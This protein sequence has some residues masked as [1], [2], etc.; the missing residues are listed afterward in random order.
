MKV[1]LLQS[2]LKWHEPDVNRRHFEGMIQEMSADVD[3]VL[4]PE[5]FTTGFTMQPEAVAETIHGQSIQWMTKMA[6]EKNFAIA[7][8]LVITENDKFYNRFI[9]INPDGSLFKYDKRHLF[10]PAGE[11]EVYCSG[12]QKSIVSYKGFR[13]C[14]NICYDLRFPAWSRNR[15]DFDCLIYVASWPKPRIHH[16][17]TLTKARAIENQCYVLAVN[18]LGV[19]ENNFEYNGHS[20]AIS[21]DG[22]TLIE[23]E[24]AGILYANL[25]K[26]AMNQYKEKLPFFRDADQIE[27]KI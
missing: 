11:G 3:V 16:W 13:F 23:Q 9:W 17:Q 6:E 10:N 8:S 12:D 14:L 2:D 24:E 27:I 21:F 19:D 4:L 15:E 20:A 25:D 26:V 18:R 1:A 5:M 7:G 22:S